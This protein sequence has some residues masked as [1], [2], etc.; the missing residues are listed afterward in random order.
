MARRTGF[1]LN[2]RDGKFLGVC[3]GIADYTGFDVLWV[4][5]AMLLGTIVG[6]GFTAVIYFVIAILASP[7]PAEFYD[8]DPEDTQFWQKTR[9]APARSIRDIRSTFR[10]VDRR[11]ADIERAYTSPQNRLSREIDALR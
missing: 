7:K 11:L 9:A 6:G 3:S 8:V 1:Y 10:D 4:R 5:A 2:K